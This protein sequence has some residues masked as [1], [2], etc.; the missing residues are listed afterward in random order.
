MNFEPVTLTGKIVRLEPLSE[1]HVPSLA[2]VGLD[3]RI[4]H[5]MR[6]GIVGTVEQL[7]DWVRQILELQT[8]GTDL[9]FTVIHL[10]SGEAIGCT[11][12]MNIDYGNR[13]LEVGGTWYGLGY[14]G[15]LVNT[16][17]KYLLIKHAFE[18]LGC[19]RV[20]LKTDTRNFRSQRA[21]EKLG[22]VK[23]GVLRNH[24]ILPDGYIR[25]SIIYSLIPEEWPGVK[26]N[27]EVILSGS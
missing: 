19:V 15:T 16:E 22:A 14:Q 25:D 6:Y 8:Q 12:Y 20:Y 27:L 18:V 4:W 10:A 5:Y 17:C 26:Q 11:R 1:A 9:P 21:I 23:E 13:S 2:K 7:T 3:E 24:M